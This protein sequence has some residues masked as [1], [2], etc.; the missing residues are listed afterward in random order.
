MVCTIDT[1]IEITVMQLCELIINHVIFRNFADIKLITISSLAMK[2]LYYYFLIFVIGKALSDGVYYVSDDPTL[3]PMDQ[4]CYNLSFYTMYPEDYFTSDTIFYFME[5]NHAIFDSELILI[6]NASNITLQGLTDTTVTITCVDGSGGLSFYDCNQIALRFLHF[7]NCG[8]AVATEL[9]D[10]LD[11]RINFNLWDY[12]YGGRYSY[13]TLLFAFVTGLDISGVTVNNSAGRAL[14]AL[15]TY[16]VHMS[17]CY[18]SYSNIKSYYRTRC[19]N[20][21]RPRCLG[22]NAF[23]LYLDT[24][25][26]SRNTESYYYVN[27]S[28]SSFSYGVDRVS[29]E[30][31]NA[32]LGFGLYYSSNIGIDVTINS[33]TLTGNTAADGANFFF[34]VVNRVHYHTLTIN[35]MT[36]TLANSIY[37]FSNTEG[38]VKSDETNGGGFYY[39]A[40][41][42]VLVFC[43]NTISRHNDTNRLTVTNSQFMHNIARDGAGMLLNILPGS[44]SIVSDRFIKLENCMFRNNFGEVGVAIFL[45]EVST[46]EPMAQL[47]FDLINISVSSNNLLNNLTTEHDVSNSAVLITSASNVTCIDVSITDHVHLTGLHVYNSVITIKETNT[48]ISNNNAE[49]GG[50]VYLRGNSVLV[51]LPP[52]NLIL[53][54]NTAAYGGAI[55]IE[56]TV[57]ADDRPLC[58]FQIVDEGS[59]ITGATPNAHIVSINNTAT[60]TGD[61]LYSSTGALFSCRFTS[62]FLYYNEPKLAFDIFVILDQ[63]NNYSTISS[64]PVRACFCDEDGLPDCSI[65]STSIDVIP[66]TYFDITVAAVGLENGVT[67]GIIN[68]VQ[69]FNGTKNESVYRVEKYCTKMSR[70]LYVLEGNTIQLTVDESTVPID[71]I[72]LKIYLNV[73]P[74]PDGFMHSSNIGSCVCNDYIKDITTCDSTTWNITREGNYWISYD[75]E[76][77]CT[78][79]FFDCPFDYCIQSSA[80][81]SPTAPDPQCNYNRAGHYVV[82]VLMDSVLC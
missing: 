77:N 5:G 44:N 67:P 4:Q 47:H 25:N 38:Y 75:T 21:R 7:R 52:A 32:G 20:Y 15:N 30:I 64:D 46:F 9:D 76:E 65:T 1:H 13:H 78:T 51:F 23:F 61:F 22:G 82:S 79:V 59:I 33:V 57:I 54:N 68:Y 43:N 36:S 12:L 49:R 27:I 35:N 8:G 37:P 69:N 58:F 28:D 10:E 3:C 48:T 24:V 63:Q 14:S 19:M 72:P 56:K 60:V 18:F 74:C 80:T 2:W 6:T 40:A 53:A 66:G 17:H 62:A 39:Q 70:L 71:N 26:C 81:F 34:A 41:G 73:F 45:R 42:V 29:S 55:Y 16:N 50:G 11:D 31:L